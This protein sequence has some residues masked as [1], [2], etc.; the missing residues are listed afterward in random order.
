MV[1]LVVF[2]E[3]RK[4][5]LLEGQRVLDLALAGAVYRQATGRHDTEGEV[6]MSSLQA[7]IEAGQRGL[8]LVRELSG[9]LRADDQPGLWSDASA[10]QLHA[11]WPGQRFALVGSNNANHVATAFTNMGTPRTV[12]EVR[13]STRKGA[14]SGFWGMARPVMGPDAQISI[15]SRASGLFDYE[16]EPGIVLGKQGKDIKAK[17]IADYI[18]GVS[19]IADWSIRDEAW[20]PKPYSP[21]MPLKN[22]DHSKSIGPCIVVD[23][24]DPND[25][26]I[27]TYVNGQR[28]QAFDTSEMIFSFGEV[29]EHFSRDFT[30]FP[31]DVIA[32]GTGA[33]TAIDQTIP[34]PD[35]SWPRDLFL[36]P[37]DEVEVRAEGIGSIFGHIV[38]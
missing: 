16:G 3:Q 11:P 24:I 38:S 29:L 15:P 4:L 31:G 37:G 27:E 23:E 14:P 18:W 25:F 17:D 26:R 1:K 34:N 8:D 32:G 30:F 33:G 9:R 19:L 6:A 12:E 28:R 10:V 13:A 20:P 35:G 2:G 21:L 22:F 7:L 5:G 36:K